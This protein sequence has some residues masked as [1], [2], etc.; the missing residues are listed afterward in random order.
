MGLIQKGFS[1]P[2]KGG[3]TDKFPKS[4]GDAFVMGGKDEE[5][6]HDGDGGG[7]D[8]NLSFFSL[9]YFLYHRIVANFHTFLIYF[10]KI[11]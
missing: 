8:R 2:R 11:Y 4:D 6:R 7:G 5:C 10:H 9:L 3:S 1:L